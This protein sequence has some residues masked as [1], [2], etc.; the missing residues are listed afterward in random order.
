MSEVS[1]ITTT[2]SDTGKNFAEKTFSYSLRL[3]YGPGV[4]VASNRKSTI[5][6]SWGRG[7]KTAG[8]YGSQSYHLHVPTVLKCGSFNLLES[9][10]PVQA[11]K[12]IAS[13]LPS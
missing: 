2:V 12:G 8:V 9:S 7:E 5:Y 4:D 1:S 3:H 11:C 13:P 6:I 10:G